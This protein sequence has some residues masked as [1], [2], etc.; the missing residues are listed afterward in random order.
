MNSV[1][2]Y[3]YCFAVALAAI[4]TFGCG[5][6]SDPGS[7]NGAEPTT[8]L[9]VRVQPPDE[10]PFPG[11]I[12]V[13]GQRVMLVARV[14]HAKGPGSEV[15]QLQ[16]YR[17][18]D[19]AV[20]T[21]DSREGGSQAVE[22][23][24]PDASVEVN[25][26]V[27]LP[28]MAGSY[29]YGACIALTNSNENCSP[30]EEIVVSESVSVITP[31][32]MTPG[33]LA[34]GGDDYF[35]LS[36]TDRRFLIVQT[37]GMT[38]TTGHLYD[39]SGMELVMNENSGNNFRIERLLVPGD[40][41]IRVRGHDSSEAGAYQ[42]DV[43]GF[44]ITTIALGSMTSGTLPA[45]GDDY[46][47]FN[48]SSKKFVTAHTTGMTDTTGHL[49]D[50]TGMELVMNENS[51][52]NFRIERLLVPGD[53]F[54]RVRGHDSL[55][56]GAYQLNI[57][58][59]A[60]IILGSMAS[61]NLTA[62]SSDY[63]QFSLS[64]KQF[65]TAHTTGSTDTT[66]HLYD[67]LG[68]ELAM[69]ENSGN[70]FR[71]ERLLV[72]GDYFVRVSGH[73]SSD[74]GDYELNVTGSALVT[75][76]SMTG[77]TLTAGVSDYFQLSLSS[78]QFVTLHTTGST[79]TT[80][81]LYD[82]LGMELAMNENSG[83]NFR[84]ERLLVAGDYFIRVSG[85]DSLVSGAYQLNVTGSAL[86]TL[87]SMTGGTLTAGVSDYFQLSL[88][89]KQFVTVTT[90]GST[91]TTGH[92]YDSLGMEL[93]MN[94]NSDNNFR[95]ERLL[96]PGDYFVRVRGHDSSDA[97]AYE[98]NV[99]GSALV[100][101]GSMTGGT[102]TAGVSDYF[103]FSLSSNQIVTVTTTGSTDTT[104]HLYDSEGVELAMNENSGNN[105]R[106]ERL[107]VPGDYFVRVRGHDSSDAG[108][109]EL[110]VSSVAIT[111]VALG[112]MT[113][114]TL[115][116]G[117]SDY[118]QFSLSSNQIVTVTTTGSTDTTGHLYD[119]RD[120]ELAMNENSGN[121]FRIERPLVPGDYF[122]RVRG[123][124]SSEAGAYE[125]NVSG[126]AIST[127]TLGSMTS[128]TLTAGGDDYFHF[129]L[130]S[131]QLLTAQT[132]GMTDTTGH[133]YDSRGMELAMNENSGN[134]FRIERPLVAGDYFVRVR[135]HDS[136]AAGTYELNVSGSAITT[137]TLGSMTSG[138]LTAGSDDYFHFSFSN[139]KVVA[140]YSTGSTDTTG[141][142]YDSRGMELAMNE[143]SGNNFRIERLLFPGGYFIRV[144][145]HSSSTSGAYTLRVEGL[146]DI[147]TSLMVP[148]MTASRIENIGD[149]NYFKFS[150]TSTQDLSIYSGRTPQIDVSIVIY[151][152]NNEVEAR[153]Q[154]SSEEG[155]DGSQFRL[156]RLFS[157]GTYYIQIA[158]DD[159]T[160]QTNGTGNYT[161]NIEIN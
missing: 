47:H 77:G 23:L 151:N 145:G 40:Y 84:I 150:L 154:D 15:T 2:F 139:G 103:Q 79:D 63:F 9:T 27:T 135:G 64:S 115:T 141:H 105:F 21:D 36:L 31:G 109:Y 89:S 160:D 26:M 85:H 76:G 120:M 161:L 68:M 111:T 138:T 6:D 157:A 19:A 1:G 147:T 62:G 117:S 126:S 53:Y 99:A 56:S 66:G 29:Y 92:L 118:F 128:G 60:S 123:H 20:S 146:V 95:I 112:S 136:S 108:A 50:S 153:N 113:P 11:G 104:G 101:L 114:G 81:H 80:G 127:V 48:L 74:A 30:G 155:D 58:G 57:T 121:N 16:F 43:S 142:L 90:T 54:I 67:S 8:E 75:L 93:A 148:S 35:Q 41:F 33:T 137:V 12:F 13:G 106:I 149:K 133:L 116:A 129:N 100:T 72:P 156:S 61:G 25:V 131:N 34:A 158:A 71:I 59:S 65:V 91:D 96:V 97:G 122:V 10:S 107:L 119:S 78:K 46:F 82:S 124:D 7:G 134:N 125:L 42:L 45:G 52:N 159:D 14:S 49:Y 17:S 88:S 73:D 87:G 130:G 83:N 32:S 143:N 28:L 55:V 5:G 152:A 51:G 94:E 86:V 70:N 44:A 140:V 4:L 102:L 38:D 110:N 24:A 132:T 39:H 18:E 3:S 37:T 69:N 22:A 98:L 144:R